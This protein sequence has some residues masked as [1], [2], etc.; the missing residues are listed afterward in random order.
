MLQWHILVGLSVYLHATKL[1]APADPP[2]RM[3]VDMKA[4]V[5]VTHDRVMNYTQ[6]ALSVVVRVI[7]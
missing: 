6:R 3:H 2:Q 4:D 7:I 1:L 5:F